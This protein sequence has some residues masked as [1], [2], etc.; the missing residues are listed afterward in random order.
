MIGQAEDAAGV[1]ADALE[2]AVAVEQAVVEDAD[3]GVG[4][5]VEPAADVDLGAAH[6][7]RAPGAGDATRRGGDSPSGE[8]GDP[9]LDPTFGEP[10]DPVGPLGDGQIMR[11]HH[12]SEPALA[13]QVAEQLDHPLA[14]APSRGFRSAR[15]PAGSPARRPARGRWRR[16]ASRR[17]IARWGDASAGGRARPARAARS[18]RRGPSSASARRSP[19]E[20]RIRC[21]SITFSTARQLGQQVVELEDEAERAVA[22]AVALAV[23]QVVDPLAIEL[24]G[25]GVGRVEQAEQVQERALARSRSPRRP[26]RT[27]RARPSGRP[28]GAPAPRSAPCGTPSPGRS[29]PG[30]MP[31]GLVSLGDMQD[32]E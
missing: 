23:G 8:G 18:P 32:A 3:L 1:R 15:R 31:S 22:E 13:V 30:G 10:N 11:D 28:R 26:R 16:A 20:S 4:L 24:D 19:G 21:G 6:P 7:S 2:D 12:H 5:L 17:R 27:R 25:A 29:R 14:A 9:L